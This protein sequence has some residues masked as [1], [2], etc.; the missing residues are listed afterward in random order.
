V[1]YV[2]DCNPCFRDARNAG[3]RFAAIIHGAQE[4]KNNVAFHRPSSIARSRLRFIRINNAGRKVAAH[5]HVAPKENL[6]MTFLRQIPVGQICEAEQDE[7]CR[8]S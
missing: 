1:P 6:I 4:E 5:I 2:T 8:W 7:R 3:R